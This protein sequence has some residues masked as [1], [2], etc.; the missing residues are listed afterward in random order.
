TR[1]FVREYIVAGEKR[2]ESG[3][4][5]LGVQLDVTIHAL[6]ESVINR[7][8]I[9]IERW[10]AANGRLVCQTCVEVAFDAVASEPA[11]HLTPRV[12]Q[13]HRDASPVI[14]DLYV[15][16][17]V[18]GRLHVICTNVRH[19]VFGAPHLYVLRDV[20]RTSLC[21]HDPG[22]TDQQRNYKERPH[23]AL[24]GCG[25]HHALRSVQ[26]CAEGRFGLFCSACGTGKFTSVP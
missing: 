7:A 17:A 26:V 2:R 9:R 10:I 21:L 25:T 18:A 14:F 4:K 22:G 16:Q 23:G 15:P 24:Q 3:W 5:L 19:T 1:N 20:W 8:C 13:T 6:G 12:Q 11:T